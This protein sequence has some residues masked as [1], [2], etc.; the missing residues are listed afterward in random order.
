MRP[1]PRGTRSFWRHFGA[2][3]VVVELA[4]GPLIFQTAELALHP[5]FQ[6]VVAVVLLR[7]LGDIAAQGS[8]IAEDQ[9]HQTQ[10]GEQADAGEQGDEQH[11]DGGDAQSLIQPIG[12]VA[13]D[14]KLT[15]FFS[16]TIS[17][18]RCQNSG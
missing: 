12:A 18:F 4:V 2:A 7:A 13:A 3:V 9:Q 5:I 14:H 15:E 1:R 10:P 6:G 16:H 8:V 17:P 11:H